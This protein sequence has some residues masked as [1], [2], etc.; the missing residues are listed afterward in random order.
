MKSNRR[1]QEQRSEATRTALINAAREQFAESG[2]SA[3]GTEAIV[4]AAG[5]TRGAMYHQFANKTELFAAVFEAVEA[6]MTRRIDAAVSN[7]GESDPIALMRL[8]AAT[9]LGACAEPEV[10]RIVLIEAPAVLGWERWREIGLRYGMGLVQ[11]LLEHGISV[12]RVAAQPVEPL[13]HVLIGALD[14][15]A[16]Y[17]AR[18]EDPARARREVG[19]VIDRL[20]QFLAV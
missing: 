1:T 2:F 6:E 4:R 20:V 10:Q 15:A 19:A 8:G 7:S 13:S 17:L 16:L 18:A 11:G 5:V 14:E 9:W 12:G 3:V